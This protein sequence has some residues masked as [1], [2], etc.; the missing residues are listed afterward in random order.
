[1]TPADF[2]A[3]LTT[4]RWSQ[5]TLAEALGVSHNTVHRYANGDRQI[6]ADVAQWLAGLA[7]EARR[8]PAPRRPPY[9][10]T[11]PNPRT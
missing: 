7:R 10:P 4:L 9:D 11:N 6:P 8:R 2:R 3:A 1:M 5:R